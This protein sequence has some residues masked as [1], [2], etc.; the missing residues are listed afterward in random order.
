MSLFFAETVTAT[1]YGLQ[2]SASLHSKS[3][4]RVSSTSDQQQ[5]DSLLRSCYST[6]ER[7]LRP[8]LCCFRPS[9]LSNLLNHCGTFKNAAVDVSLN[10]CHTASLKNVI[11]QSFP[12]LSFIK[13]ILTMS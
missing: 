4:S 8:T 5:H 11:V 7:H 13:N 3:T 2:F 9:L 10:I 12:R 1:I 6:H